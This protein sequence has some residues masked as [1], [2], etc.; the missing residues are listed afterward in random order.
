MGAGRTAAASI[1]AWLAEDTWVLPP[2]PVE[3]EAA[4]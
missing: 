4:S 2:D 3:A 1:E